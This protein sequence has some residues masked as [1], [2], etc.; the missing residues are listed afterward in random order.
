MSSLVDLWVLK[1]L[2]R[3]TLL[4]DWIGAI[5]FVRPDKARAVCSES[6]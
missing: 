5:D 1:V 2:S 3:D 4:N 6:C